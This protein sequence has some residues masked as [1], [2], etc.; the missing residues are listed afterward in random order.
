MF[1]SLH[2]TLSQPLGTT[3]GFLFR[4]SR[5]S[6]FADT[7]TGAKTGEAF[8]YRQVPP[9]AAAMRTQPSP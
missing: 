2:L 5:C 8:G 1:E 3:T 4:A 6:T 9:S 7:L